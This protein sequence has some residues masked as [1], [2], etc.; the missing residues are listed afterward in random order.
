[1]LLERA[2]IYSPQKMSNTTKWLT[3][4]EIVLMSFS[5]QKKKLE[6]EIEEM[7]ENKF[8][9]WAVFIKRMTLDTLN[10]KIAR[11]ENWESFYSLNS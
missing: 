8:S 7:I 10:K 1:M 3:T 9:K 5:L 4:S 6:K 11:L 2:F